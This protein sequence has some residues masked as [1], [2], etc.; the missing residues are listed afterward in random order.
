MIDKLNMLHDFVLVQ[1]EHKE[2]EGNIFLPEDRIEQNPWVK[3]LAVGPGRL[4]PNGQRTIM[5]AKVGMRGFC[6][7]Y[8]GLRINEREGWNSPIII[9]DCSL[10]LI[11]EG[12]NG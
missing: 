2:K 12:E 9:Q 7:T 3:V 11:D 5:N 1:R 6:R 8:T 10:E 4:L